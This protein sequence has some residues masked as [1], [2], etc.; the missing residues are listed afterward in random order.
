MKREYVTPSAYFE[1]F[2]PNQFAG[3]CQPGI[4]EKDLTPKVVDCYWNSGTSATRTLYSF[5]PNSC[6][7]K[8]SESISGCSGK[9]NTLSL[10][11]NL[12]QVDFSGSEKYGTGVTVDYAVI[13]QNS[14]F[15]GCTKTIF[16][17]PMYSWANGNAGGTHQAKAVDVIP[18]QSTD[19]QGRPY[20][21]NS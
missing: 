4:S 17:G 21:F 7:Q 2:A 16:N 20:Y 18:G 8:S 3:N 19:S 6:R 9:G 12:C 14:T 13:T 11:T 15:M 5:N 10:L 1:M